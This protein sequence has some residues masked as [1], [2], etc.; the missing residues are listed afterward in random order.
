VKALRVVGFVS[1]ALLAP[2]FASSQDAPLAIRDARVVTVA[3]PVIEKGTVVVHKGR[4]VAAGPDVAVPAGATIV[5]GAGKT[6]YPG[7]VDALTTIGLAEISAVPATLDTTELGD[8]NPH[9]RAWIAL[10]PDSELVPVPRANGVTTVLSAPLG[11]LVSGQSALV[12]LAGTTPASM[13]VKAPAALHVVYPSGRPA[14]D[15]SRPFEPQEP[16]TL[17]ERLKDREKAQKQALERLANLLAEAK[18]YAAGATDA[19]RPPQETSMALEALAPFARGE[20]PVVVRVDD[21]DEIKSAVRFASDNGLK[22]IVAGGLEAWR[23]AALLKEKDVAVLVKVLRLPSR[24][25]DPYDAPYANAAVLHRAGVRFAIVSDDPEMSRNLPYEA[26]MAAAYGLPADVAL[27][28]ITLSP[29]EIF[30]ASELVGSIATGREA[31]LVL[32]SGDIL[33]TRTQV[34]HVFVGGVAQS[35]ETRHSRLYDRYK[36]RP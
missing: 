34:T 22:L 3:G 33:D 25:S 26:A 16:K 18:A 1:G 36:D 17:A 13:V 5:E 29:A 7:L 27:R 10:H 31:N 15:P 20:A 9:A 35:L 14:V 6:L 32:A 12:R 2:V 11:G 21:E 28:A 8:V 30:G 19:T 4:I 24:E 23:C